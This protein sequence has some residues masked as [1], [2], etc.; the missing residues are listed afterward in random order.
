MEFRVL[1]PVKVAAEGQ[2]VDVGHPRQR[3]VLAVLVVRLNHAVPTERLVDCVW[4]EHPPASARNVLYG[5]VARLRAALAG[6]GAPDALARHEGGYVIRADEDQ[7]DLYRFRRLVAEARTADDDEKAGLLRAALGLWRGEALGRLSSPWLRAMRDTLEQQRMAAVLDLGDIMLRRG[8]HEAVADELAQYAATHPADERLTAQ[9]MTALQRSGRRGEAL[10]RFER[11]RRWLAREL[12]VDPG[13]ELQALHQRLLRNDGSPSPN[14]SA[15]GSS[16]APPRELP[17]DVS[18]FTGRQAELAELDSLLAAPAVVAGS[19]AREAGPAVVI[20]AV[21]GTAG[22]GKTALAIR[23]ARRVAGQFPDGQLY[24]NLRGFD[25]VES[26][27]AADVLASFLRA[28]GV[29]GKDVPLSADERAARYR[30][31]LAG[32]RVLVVLD[33]AADGDQVRP[34][35]PGSPGCAAVVTSRN[36][37]AG[38]VSVDGAR[39][40]DLDLLPQP[41]AVELLRALIGTRVDADPAAAQ[42]LAR[43]CSRLP[44]ALR[45]AA[46]LA[47]AHPDVPL[48]TLAG[49][50][51]DQR[52]RLDLLDASGDPRG[53]V[54]T[55]FSW[56]YLKLDTATARV[57]RLLGLHPGADLDG[58]AVAALTGSGLEQADRALDRLTHAHLVSSPTRGR[59]AMHDLLRAYAR[60]LSAAD[61]GEAGQR[62]ALTCLFDHYLYR[63]AVAMDRLFPAQRFRPSIPAPAGPVPMLADPAAARAWLDTERANLVTVAAYMSSNGWTRHAIHLAA[64]L[65]RYLDLGG[66]FPEALAVHGYA[67]LA[68]SHSGDPAAEANAVNGLGGVA[69]R[70]GQHRLAAGHYRQALELHHLAGDQAGEARALRNLGMTEIELGHLPEAA[71]YMERALILSRGTGDRIGEAHAALNL[72]VI[73]L[74]QGSYEQALGCEQHALAAFRA[75][76]DLLGESHALIELALIELGQH[77]PSDAEDHIRQAL[78]MV[79]EIGDRPGVA[80]ALGLLGEAAFQR[81]SYD[82]A[83]RHLRQ[84]LVLHRKIGNR[85]GEAYALNVL[86]DVLLSM[87]VPSEARA[88]HS[89]ALGLSIQTGEREGEARAHSGLA[90]GY[91][92]AGEFPLARQHWEQALAAYTE[93]GAPEAGN[94]RAKLASAD[95]QPP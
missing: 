57:F 66:H 83:T 34:L 64:T 92:A 45:V 75:T 59:Y 93:L 22:V 76:G 16:L 39:R 47:A 14:G 52:R 31:L 38:L 32:R 90:A 36:R 11:T 17:A 94:V 30:S 73:A 46:E 23:W 68:A 55:V 3:A 24:A 25:V 56:S 60:D 2:Q 85:S 62:A 86:G 6:A 69:F 77:R 19:P 80:D 82:Q 41:D 50:L 87:G 27:D 48:A 40:L 43:Q 9:L 72:G 10:Q 71:G 20:S 12:G 63:A 89:A 61:D 58:Y 49:E 26:V 21:S 67:R 44:L 15:A 1:G 13:P 54:R 91:H 79:R 8:E 81:D 88:Q 29:A 95:G 35:L 5:Y 18:A 84:S 74:K 42:A 33:N 7:V 51:A 78:P 65:F 70:Q 28:L 37:L 53:A 4:G